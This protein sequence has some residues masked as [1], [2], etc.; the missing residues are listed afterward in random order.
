[1]K[2]LLAI[3]M[4]LVISVMVIPTSVMAVGGDGGDSS[5]GTL[6]LDN[7]NP[8]TWQRMTDGKYGIFTYN[9]IGNTLDWGLH[10]QGLDVSTGY[11]LI[12]YANPYPGNFP[13][14]LIW[15]GTS[16][17][18]GR[19]DVAS[20]STDLGMNLPT[21]PDSNMVV[22]HN[23]TPDFY[24]PPFNFGAK[25]WL[26]PTIC[27]NAGTKSIIV[28]SPESFLF[29]TG[30]INYTDTNLV[31]GGTSSGTTQLTTTIIEPS[32][33]LEVLPTTL[34]FGSVVVGQDSTERAIAIRN[35]GSVPIKVTATTSAGFYTDCMWISPGGTFY[36]ANG[37]ES[38]TILAGNTLTV[39]TKVHPTAAYGTVVTGSIT[40]VAEYVAP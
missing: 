13:G 22:D 6:I 17:V 35:T 37:W 9:S 11:S 39:Y 32:V 29:E 16:G 1:M 14:A 28:W 33:G 23:V 27:Y 8:E 7:K 4:V 3:L 25:V 5:M 20:F 10:V 40:F 19:I 26:V 18:D 36:L 21:A 38:S 2:K 12:Y 34:D 24:P 15:S 31:V 30:L